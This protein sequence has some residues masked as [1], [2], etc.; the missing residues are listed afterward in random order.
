MLKESTGEQRHKGPRV[1]GGNRIRESQIATTARIA[2]A[3]FRM[4]MRTERQ[5]FSEPDSTTITNPYQRWGVSR[6]VDMTAPP[7]ITAE[8]SRDCVRPSSSIGS[9]RRLAVNYHEIESL[10]RTVHEQEE[11]GSPSS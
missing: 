10:P 7:G 5:N 2:G 11:T 6:E 4:T 9:S 1:P 8:T 3:N